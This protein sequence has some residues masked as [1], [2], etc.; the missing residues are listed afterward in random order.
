MRQIINRLEQI[1]KELEKNNTLNDFYTSQKRAKKERKRD[2]LAMEKFKLRQELNDRILFY[3]FVIP[4]EG[5]I[6][7]KNANLS[8]SDFIK[9]KEKLNGR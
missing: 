1:E 3:G 6:V 8:A 7:E 5:G 4:G 9:K 2:Y